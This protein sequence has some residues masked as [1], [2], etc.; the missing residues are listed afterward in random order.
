MYVYRCTSFFKVLAAD[1]FPRISVGI[2]RRERIST[3]EVDT[4]SSQLSATPMESCFKFLIVL[5]AVLAVC[6]TV[7]G[8]ISIGIKRHVYFV[9]QIGAGVTLNTH[10]KS[11]DDD[12]GLR[13]LAYNDMIT[14]HFRTDFLDATMFWCDVDWWDNK[15]KVQIKGNFHIYEARYDIDA[16][17]KNC[18]RIAKYDAVYA[19][20]EN[21][22][23][24]E[25]ILYKWPRP[26]MPESTKPYSSLKGI[27]L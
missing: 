15:T 22:G 18:T 16:C 3:D 10:C 14:W 11:K 26:K 5:V 4:I 9:N 21:N 8:G 27:V 19:F 13:H 23:G 12:L 1:H 17:G 6:S 20:D 24:L 25:Y 7:S 2:C